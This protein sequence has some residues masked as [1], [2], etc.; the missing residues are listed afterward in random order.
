MPPFQS[1]NTA[2]DGPPSGFAEQTTYKL[3]PQTFPTM[4]TINAT[5]YPR[6]VLVTWIGVQT[7]TAEESVLG[8]KIRYWPT[9][10]DYRA[11][12]KDVDA[13]LRT[14]AY[15]QNMPLDERFNVRVYAYSRAGVGK[16][17]SPILQFQMIPRHLCVP[18]ASWGEFQ[19]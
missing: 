9:G 17:S 10:A 13:G 8:Y 12:F 1:F 18:G 16:M 5:Q 3:W 14:Y 19:K 11:T 6:T 15:L 4:V 2:G 7:T